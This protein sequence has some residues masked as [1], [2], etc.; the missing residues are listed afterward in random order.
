MLST[1]WLVH[2]T[3]LSLVVWFSTLVLFLTNKAVAM[4]VHQNNPILF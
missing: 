4:S 3:L 1:A 2:G